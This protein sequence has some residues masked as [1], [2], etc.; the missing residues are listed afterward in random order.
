MLR[1]LSCFTQL[2]RRQCLI[3]VAVHCTLC[4]YCPTKILS[5]SHT[6]RIGVTY[7]IW[8]TVKCSSSFSGNLAFNHSEVTNQSCAAY[9]FCG[10]KPTLKF[11]DSTRKCKGRPH[12]AL[13]MVI[14]CR[15]PTR[16]TT[17][18]PPRTHP[19]RFRV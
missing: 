12:P 1:H 4:I 11:W 10:C 15:S 13:M 5:A 7:H 9:R 19:I 2:E 18:H 17:L 6:A 3:S 16:I 14:I 8:R